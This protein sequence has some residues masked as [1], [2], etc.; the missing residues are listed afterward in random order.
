MVKLSNATVRVVFGPTGID[1]IELR[2][3]KAAVDIPATL[4]GEGAIG[5]SGGTL[6]AG[7][8]LEIVPLKVAA[9]ADLVLGDAGFVALTVGVRF[10]APLPFANSGLGL[11]GLLGRFASNGER[12]M[13]RTETDVVKRESTGS[14]SRRTRSTSRGPGSTPSASAPSSAPS[15]TPASPS[16]PSAC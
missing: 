10:P 11:Y 16:T 6:H 7:V 3:L 4:K 14:R 8:A 12:A 13:A 2:G 5:V 1:G 9:L 15:P